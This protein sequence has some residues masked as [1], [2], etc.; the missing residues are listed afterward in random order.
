MSLAGRIAALAA[1]VGLEFQ[2]KVSHAHPG[3]AR[4]WVSFGCI[5]GEIVVY[6]S[7]GVAA[8]TRRQAGRYRVFFREPFSDNTYCWMAMARSHTDTGMH[9]ICVVR[10]QSDRKSR[11]Y[12]DISCATFSVCF[13][14]SS[15]INLMVYR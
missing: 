5:D 15:E 12:V 13:A 7:F 8:V 1:R 6:R 9:P 14:D 2:T 11:R 3:V 10:A 4:A